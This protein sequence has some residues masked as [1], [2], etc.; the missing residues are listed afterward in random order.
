M[1]TT[2]II[3]IATAITL[4]IIALCGVAT[5]NAEEIHISENEG[6]YFTLKN[7]VIFDGE[8]TYNVTLWEDEESDYGTCTIN[9]FC[10]DGT[11]FAI[12]TSEA[13]EPFV[14]KYYADWIT[15][16]EENDEG[17]EEIVNYWESLRERIF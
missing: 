7:V 4:V 12:L 13:G 10:E 6:G 17:C 14:C 2:K 15:D 11:L 9:V 1:K 8:I 5:A 3:T 16:E